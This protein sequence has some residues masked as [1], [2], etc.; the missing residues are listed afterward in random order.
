MET[1]YEKLKQNMENLT[2]ETSR[3]ECKIL[4]HLA[5]NYYSYYSQ[6]KK[7]ELVKRKLSNIYKVTFSK[8]ENRTI[9]FL[10]KGQ[11]DIRFRLFLEFYQKLI[12]R[13][14][15]DTN[16]DKELTEW[17]FSCKDE[18]PELFKGLDFRDYK[19]GNYTLETWIMES[20]KKATSIYG[21]K[22]HI[23]LG[24]DNIRKA[25]SIFKKYKNMP[26]I[27]EEESFNSVFSESFTNMLIEVIK[28]NEPLL[29]LYITPVRAQLCTKEQGGREINNKAWKWCFE[30][31]FRYSIS[32]LKKEIES[33]KKYDSIFRQF[34][35]ISRELKKI[36]K[37]LY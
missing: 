8:K 18:I 33:I 23:E 27:S 21:D 1:K 19:I 35:S 7:L 5:Q 2:L 24:L 32:R 16:F 22:Y 37:Q 31:D 3:R 4:I 9:I 20:C 30:K 29:C 26:L 6:F 13:R 14:F 36:E 34:E 11:L 25:I 17:I 28:Y 10:K 15:P 12:A